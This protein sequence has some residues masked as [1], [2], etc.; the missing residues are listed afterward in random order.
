MSKD[1]E[2]LVADFTDPDMTGEGR[3]SVLA[4]ARGRLD[5]QREFRAKLTEVSAE[6]CVDGRAAADL[7]RIS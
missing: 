4:Y 6:T 7:R 2:K 5:A 3:A 1:V